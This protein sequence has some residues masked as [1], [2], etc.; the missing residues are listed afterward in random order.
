MHKQ[1]PKIQH[2]EIREQHPPP[3]RLP[4]HNLGTHITRHGV[5]VT[6]DKVPRYP[7]GDAVREA[8]QPVAE[9]VWVAGEAP[10]AGSQEFRAG[11]GLHVFEV[12]DAGVGGVRAETAFFVVRCAEDVESHRLNESYEG[13]A[14][15]AEVDGVDGE[16][17]GLKAVGE[18]QPD[19]VAE[20]EH[21]AEAVGGDVHLGGDGWFHVEGIGDVEGLE[22]GDDEDAVGDG[23]V[24]GVLLGDEG[25]VQDDPAGEARAHLVEGLDVDGL[26]KEAELRVEF[27]PDEEVVE[28]VP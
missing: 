21:E 9:V 6:V 5:G 7:R 10:P 15:V 19:E 25:E 24:S 3:P 18:G 22:G 12:G 20:G 1:Y 16:V 4:L 14:A 17:A 27:P 8:H 23:G 26:P 2:I 13:D 28:H 11:G